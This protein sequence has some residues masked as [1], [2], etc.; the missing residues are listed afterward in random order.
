MCPRL[1]SPVGRSDRRDGPGSHQRVG[2]IQLLG[3]FVMRTSRANPV[4][5]RLPFVTTGGLMA[6]VAST[7]AVTTLD[8][9]LWR[10]PQS[11]P[12]SGGGSS[13]PCDIQKINYRLTLR[14]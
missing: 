3:H 10:R 12:G 6:A 2:A 5:G 11:S 7:F 8:I 4:N 13:G 1:R 9:A 14:S